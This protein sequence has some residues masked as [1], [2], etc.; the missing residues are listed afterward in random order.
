MKTIIT[1]TQA[2]E[3]TFFSSFRNVKR[4]RWSEHRRFAL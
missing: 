2:R 1:P 4:I 3:N